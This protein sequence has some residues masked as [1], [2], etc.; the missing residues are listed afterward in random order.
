V[1]ENYSYLP[2]EPLNPQLALKRPPLEFLLDDFIP[3]GGL[4]MLYGRSGAGKTFLALDWAAQVAEEAPVIYLVTEGQ[5]GFPGRIAA[6]QAFHER[7][8]GWGMQ[9]IFRAI[10]LLDEEDVGNLLYTAEVIQPALLVFDTLINCIPGADENSA[11]DMGLAIRACQ[12]IARETEAAI[13]LIH[14]KTKSG[15][16]ERGSSVLRAAM[17]VMVEIDEEDGLYTVS[18]AKAKDAAPFPDVQYR[19]QPAADSCLLVPTSRAEWQAHY[20]PL[21]ESEQTVLGVMAREEFAEKGVKVADIQTCLPDFSERT[22][23]RTLGALKE[24]GLVGQERERAPYHVA[25]KGKAL[26][27]AQGNGHSPG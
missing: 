15:G 27:R 4:V 21:S 6:W 11:K 17:D 26:L 16:W 14:H 25:E 2:F 8:M 10:N 19:L 9:F 20:Q 23:Y 12:L 3:W 7:P 18:C 24:R 1:E 13:L 5:G 22:I